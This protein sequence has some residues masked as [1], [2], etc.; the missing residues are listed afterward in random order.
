MR[1]RMTGLVFVVPVSL[2][3]VATLGA[4]LTV[5]VVK[6]DSGT[7]YIRADGNIDPS[8]APIS[9]ID[10]VTYTFADDIHDEI[11][12][13]RSNVIIDGNGYVLQGNGS[14]YRSGNGFSLE[15]VSNV[16]IKNVNIQGFYDGVA[17][18]SASFANL[19][20]NN[21]TNNTVGADLEWS[22]NN[23]I[24]QNNI[25][26]NVAYGVYVSPS[27]S[28]NTITGNNITNNRDY[29]LYLYGS[30]SDNT[31]ARNKIT[32]N[33]VGIYLETSSKNH[34]SR[35]NV[36]GNGDGISLFSS[37][38]NDISYNSIL[39]NGDG[40]SLSWESSNNNVYDNSIV[41]N[42]N[43]GI[44]LSISSNY[45]S[46]SGNSIKNNAVGI[47][48]RAGAWYNEQPQSS[49]NNTVYHNNIMGNQ[50][51][52]LDEESSMNVWDNGY[53]SGGNY[54]NDYNGTDSYGGPSQD[55]LGS[56]GIGDTIYI[57]DSNNTDRY[58][59]IN[60][61]A[62]YEAGLVVSITTPAAISLGS[63]SSL[64]AIVTNEGSNDD[65]NVEFSL[66][67]NGTT[68]NS[69]TVPILKAGDS[70]TLSYLWTPTVQ[71]TYNVTA[72]AT[73]VSGET[74]L[75][76]DQET[77]F[78]RIV[79]VGVKAG[80]WIK[81]DYTLTGWPAGTPYPKWL[82]L[83]FLSVQG[84]AAT[85]RVTMHMSDGTE[86]NATV[87][88]DVVGGGQALGLS[89]FAI[90]ANLTVG[91]VVYISGYGNVKIAGE[92]IGSYAG[93]S[94]TTVYASLSLYGTQ[95]TY[96]W[97]KQ[98]GVMVE[99]STASGTMTG[100][101]KA[102]ETNVWKAQPFGLPIDPV[103][104]CVLIVV[105]IVIVGSAAFL[106]M[107]RKKKPIEATASETEKHE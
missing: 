97:D 83:E 69:T 35:N 1:T 77:A 73:A 36:A 39:N 64:S 31:I 95:L 25:T 14:G 29:G 46:I 88:V 30:S 47:H 99:A 22:S 10:N 55:R 62:S 80:D 56:D 106:V 5:P 100:T 78:V 90:P 4:F 6:C 96:R 107:R 58:P 74:S 60:P 16:V 92:T 3:L 45:N 91:D 86:Q 68:L 40:I 37:S 42:N 7:I 15:S 32:S 24:L 87:P 105:A 103:I 38:N 23:D 48:A 11:V 54:W 101:G 82:R 33:G 59:L 50:I 41:N 84:M 72:Y 65:L 18:S 34:V 13:E 19:Y 17:L 43:D 21:I 61:L 94:R 104:L 66:F 27:S 85:V 63:S 70:H 51:Q 98:T 9:S 76:C 12:V 49:S 81:I 67:L 8:T 20:A 52:A 93:A 75:G 26:S 79:Q 53:P 102:T 57:I 71:G 28:S 89:G 44:Y 2:L